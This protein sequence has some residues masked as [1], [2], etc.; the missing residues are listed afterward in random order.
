MLFLKF[1]DVSIDSVSLIFEDLFIFKR[2]KTS[3]IV[4]FFL[5]STFG[6][7]EILYIV[8]FILS[9]T[10]PLILI[11]SMIF[12]CSPFL[13]FIRGV[14]IISDSLS[15]YFSYRSSTIS[16]ADFPSKLSPC[17]GHFGTPALAKSN[18]R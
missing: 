5:G 17:I 13:L 9:L 1:K 2:S 6:S 10:N 4:L 3:S 16:E 12:L 14:S 18:L 11:S 8:L 15:S 7:S